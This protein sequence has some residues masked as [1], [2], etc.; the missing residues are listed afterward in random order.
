[1]R[2]ALTMG[3]TC[4]EIGESM[5]AEELTDWI[6]LD[7]V[8]PLPDPWR[9]A[10]TIAAVIANS[11]TKGRRWKPEDFIPRAR[12]PQKRMSNAQIQAALAGVPGIKRTVLHGR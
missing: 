7:R 8:W 6:A 12:P 3:R 10:G 5:S 9:Q 11:L 1:M 2:L 4:E